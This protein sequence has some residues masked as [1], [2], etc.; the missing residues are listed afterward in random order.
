MSQDSSRLGGA[1]APKKKAGENRPKMNL[2]EE[3]TAGGFLQI[4]GVVCVPRREHDRRP[5]RFHDRLGKTS[6]TV[7]ASL[8]QRLGAV[9]RRSSA[10]RRMISAIS[11]LLLDSIWKSTE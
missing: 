7:A 8:F 2:A 6:A 3:G 11:G 10:V 1:M 5:S 9:L 4:T